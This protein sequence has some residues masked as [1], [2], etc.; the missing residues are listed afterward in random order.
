MLAAPRRPPRA[1][2]LAPRARCLPPRR[3]RPA[4]ARA[5]SGTP[6]CR[7]RNDRLLQLQRSASSHL[8]PDRHP[9]ASAIPRQPV[10]DQQPAQT[11]S[12]RVFHIGQRPLRL[13]RAGHHSGCSRLPKSR[14]A[15]RSDYRILSP[16]SRKSLFAGV[17]GIRSRRQHRLVHAVLRA[18][19]RQSRRD[20]VLTST[21]TPRSSSSRTWRGRARAD[22]FAVAGLDALLERLA[23]QRIEHEPIETY[24]NGVRHVNIPDPDGNAIAFGEPPDAASASPRSAGTGASS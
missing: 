15:Q 9:R 2:R 4:P 16:M 6:R 17:P 8:A 24:S 10:G 13:L 21:S 5:H 14:S 1:A 23:A 19:P 11:A 20:E 3:P 22:P 18:T 12:V 7:E